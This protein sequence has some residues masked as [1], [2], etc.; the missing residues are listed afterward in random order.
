MVQTDTTALDNRMKINRIA[1]AAMTML[2]HERVLLFKDDVNVTETS[3]QPHF[4]FFF[5]MRRLY[6]LYH[7]MFVYF[8]WNYHCLIENK[9]ILGEII[10]VND[11]T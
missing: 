4:F 9:L 8:N 6:N 11:E 3:Q 10:I 7:E 5:W 1:R 2:S